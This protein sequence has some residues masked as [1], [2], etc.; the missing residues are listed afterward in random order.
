MVGTAKRLERGPIKNLAALSKAYDKLLQD[1][2]YLEETSR[3]TADEKFVK[4]RL[5]KATSAFADV[6]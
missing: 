1:P 2:T 5:Q 3:S 4:D 6:E